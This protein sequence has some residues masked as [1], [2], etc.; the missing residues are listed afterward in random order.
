[1]IRTRPLVALLLAAL[2]AAPGRG[3]EPPDD[4]T[5]V[6]V[7]ATVDTALYA[8][9]GRLSVRLRFTSPGPLP[10]R[11][12]VLMHLARPGT[13]DTI[14]ESDH[15]PATRTDR[16]EAGQPVTYRVENLVPPK[17]DGSRPALLV[18]VGLVDPTR[19]NGF[20]G[21]L[22]LEGEEPFGDRRYVAARV[23]AARP[24]KRTV[25]SL[26]ELAR[27]REKEGRGPQAFHL[28]EEAMALAAT[29]ADKLAVTADLLAQA[30]FKAEGVSGPE[31]VRIDRLVAGE[32]LR[33]LR[34]RASA[35]LRRKELKLALRVLE[36]IGGVAEEERNTRVAGEP[37]SVKRAQKDLVDLRARLLALPPEERPDRRAAIEKAGG[38]PRR[39]LA[40]AKKLAR[41]GR[42]RLARSLLVEVLLGQ[43][44]P[45]SLKEEA[46]GLLEP[47]QE[48]LTRKLSPEEERRLA[49]VSDHPAFHR[50][51]TAVSG[52]FVFLGPKGLVESIPP[53]SRHRFDVA[54]LLLTDLLGR[55]AVEPGQRV[56]VFF[57]ETWDFGGATAG[58]SVIN[59]GRADPKAR[60]TR[61]DTG[62]YYHE[63]THCV[64]DTRPL[65]TV[66]GGLTEGIA[67]VGA[68]F[69]EDMFAVSR[70]RFEDLARGPRAA[71]RRYHLDREEAYW[72]IPGYAPSAGVLLELL[73]RHAPGPDGHAD[74]A[75]LG[76]FFRAY[77]LLAVK[78]P[79][80][81]RLSSGLGRA[82]EKS[83]GPE[84]WTTLEELRYPVD[85]NRAREMAELEKTH[86]PT[87]IALA[88]R[89]RIAELLALAEKT[90]PLF[91]AARARH[92]ALA[93]LGAS[94]RAEDARAV[95]ARRALGVVEKL[96]VI[97]PFYGETGEPLAEPF[98]PEHEL[99]LEKEYV[100][101]GDVARWRVPARG[102]S[103]YARMDARGL[104]RFDY[105]YPA[106]A[107]TYA[108]AH[109]SVPDA[110][111]AIA[112]LAADDEVALWVNGRFVQRVRGRR[113]FLPDFER[114]PIRLRAG[115]NRLFAK[116]R[117]HHGGTGFGL[118]LTRPDGRPIEGLVA[119]LEPP[120][121]EDIPFAETP[122]RLVTRFEDRYRR[123]SLGRRYEVAAG[124]FR[125]RNKVLRGEAE[126]APAGWRP[127][128]VRPG[129]PQDRPAALAWLVLPG[130]EPPA[131]F[132]WTIGLA[133][134]RIPKIALTWDG[135]GDRET[136]SGWS[137]VLLPRDG[138]KEAT[139]RLE[140]YD[141]PHV[142]RHVSAP[143]TWGAAR[144]VIRR[145]DGRVSVLVG[146]TAVLE[147][148]SAPPLARRRFGFAVWEPDVGLTGMSL[149][150]P[151]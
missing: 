100:S 143:E 6:S 69:V 49:E 144:I 7:S 80:T 107:V 52:R 11:C 98:P 131:D 70:G 125:C 64:D 142:V 123:R 146:G 136:L 139:L 119:D 1:M 88:R 134:A 116:I 110:R 71:L 95:E 111:E 63:F 46:R 148:V 37:S 132:A 29:T 106:Q 112:W 43:K 33:F 39:L 114:W 96:R 137:L 40:T 79:R 81:H 15:V 9:T 22:I 12:R 27:L 28:R 55:A 57:K 35:L 60:G 109:V 66:K 135:E 113:P 128:A 108:L 127:F 83:L 61:V 75:R 87:L 56:I 124:R 129:F 32:K 42:L 53:A 149:A 74:W 76:A 97:G 31:Q 102:A 121:A 90:D 25:E 3:Q 24:E 17:A 94:G 85:R 23:V 13:G 82:L 150:F 58:G 93:L 117:N 99:D 38:D 103:H 72:R 140:R 47:L 122:D 73:A 92:A 130:K 126:G 19:D 65:H 10:V 44:N 2:L 133:S 138:G 51:A 54:S 101:R 145:V 41:H 67:D 62:L 8:E 4:R 14:V 120:R 50:L 84:V 141:V 18:L 104:V 45:E 48:E 91:V 5:G 151:K 89:G 147:N 77:R 21:R 36:R 26:L 78:S 86:G 20:H 118:R 34:D 115:R 16:W 59:V 30:P 105:G 68:I